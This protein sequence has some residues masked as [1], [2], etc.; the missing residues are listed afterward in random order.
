MTREYDGAARTGTAAELAAVAG[1]APPNLG[2]GAVSSSSSAIGR[3]GPDSSPL[4][5]AGGVILLA[6]NLR[7]LVV[8]VGPMLGLIRAD[9]HM[10]ATM[11]GLLTTLPIFCFG[12]FAPLAP[13]LTGRLGIEP[14]LLVT[15]VMICAGAA[16]RL[17]PSL[18]ML[19]AGTVLLG[20]GIAMAN[21]LI[22]SVIKRDFA[23]HVGLMTGLYTTMLCL[24]PAAAAG[25]TVPLAHATGLGW[26]WALA[27]WGL[28]AVLAALVWLPQVRRHTR[29]RAAEAAATAHPVRGLWRNRLAWTVTCYMGL[30]SLTS[31]TVFAW[32]PSRL[33]DA[34]LSSTNA[35]AVLS[36][37][38]LVSVIAAFGAPMLI[39]RGVRPGWL[40]VGGALG[41]AI[42]LIG[43]LVAPLG[44]AYPFAALLGLC[45]GLAI[46]LAILFIVHR[47][48]DNRHAAQLSSMAQS[49]GYLLA[50][51][52]PVVL[53]A[54][55]QLTGNWTVPF[56]LLA[57]TLIP[58]ALAG[59]GAARNR[60]VTGT[61]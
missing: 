20:A 56:L 21:V 28:P 25:L 39:P 60:H 55:H 22:P 52:G 1:T 38:N 57:T 36:V 49:F 27:L 50:A 58:Q 18:G 51:V 3:R 35:G 44:G 29:M 9:T 47:S 30:Q 33:T 37:T 11:A 26:R 4:L 53:G 23:N 2:T 8:A 45:Q 34:G 41:Y 24:S 61:R 5:L 40:A 10:S 42:A 14:A 54:A 32:L 43:F 17:V 31:Y 6:L 7:P 19:L 13:R 48:P 15:M 59:F 16:L 12:A 46:S